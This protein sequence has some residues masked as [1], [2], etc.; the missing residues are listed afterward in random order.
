MSVT[1]PA[2]VPEITQTGEEAAYELRCA[3]G[4]LWTASRLVIAC[5]TF[6]FGALGFA[7]FYLRSSN[8]SGLWRPGGV[9]A[10]GGLGSA[11]FALTLAGA[12]LAAYGSYRLRR[13]STVDWEVAGW[14]AVFAALVAAGLQAFELTRLGFWPGSSGYASVFVG[15]APLNVAL[16]LSAAYWLETLLARS[17]RLRRALAQDGGAASSQRPPARLFRASVEGC[18]YF[19]SYV[20]IVALVFWLLFYVVH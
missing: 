15:F 17:I 11:V 6:A 8:S 9:T 14:L 20:A 5:V 7:Y 16:L 4:S 2:A 1:N 18:T 19:W 12:A 10:P 13:G 3:E